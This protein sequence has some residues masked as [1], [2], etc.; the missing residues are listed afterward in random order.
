MPNS[1]FFNSTKFSKRNWITVERFDA[2][3]C[4]K[5]ISCFVQLDNLPSRIYKN[6]LD[7]VSKR[8]ANFQKVFNFCY[9]Y[10]HYWMKRGRG[11][12][13]CDKIVFNKIRSL[14]GGKMDF[15]LVGGA[16]LCE[17]THDFIRTCLGVTVVQVKILIEDILKLSQG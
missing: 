1:L 10:K 11:T 6:I 5:W 7:S 12:P 2:H 15:V 13:I 17:K 14:L 8:G 9:E 4:F 3:I 16:P